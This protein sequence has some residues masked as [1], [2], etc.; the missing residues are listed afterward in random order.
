MIKWR[1]LIAGRNGVGKSTLLKLIVNQLHPQNGEIKLGTKTQIAY[2]DQ[3]QK[4][5]NS[6]NKTILEFFEDQGFSQK[7]IRAILSKYLFWG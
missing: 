2:Y 5:I 7:S 3:E 6:T 4:E 1:I